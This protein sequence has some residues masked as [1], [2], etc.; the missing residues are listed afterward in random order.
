MNTTLKK[1]DCV[2]WDRSRIVTNLQFTE[3][4]KN[5]FEKCKFT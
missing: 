2:Q 3:K 1:F 5:K 4:Q